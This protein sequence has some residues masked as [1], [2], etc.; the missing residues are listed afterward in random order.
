MVRK[1]SKP[2]E[3]RCTA[4]AEAAPMPRIMMNINTGN[5]MFFFMSI[6]LSN[7]LTG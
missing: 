2:G 4:Y 6:Y 7:G 5:E 1:E 3:T